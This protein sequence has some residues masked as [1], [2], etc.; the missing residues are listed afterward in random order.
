[1]VQ[2]TSI[3]LIESEYFNKSPFDY[4]I[5]LYPPY[6]K[7]INNYLIKKDAKSIFPNNS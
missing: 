3:T 2:L 6:L 4:L 5:P 7:N 1:M